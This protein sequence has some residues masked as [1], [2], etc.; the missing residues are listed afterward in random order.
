MESWLE[1]GLEGLGTDG[2]WVNG[3][4]AVRWGMSC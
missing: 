2:D 3:D 1:E 4:H